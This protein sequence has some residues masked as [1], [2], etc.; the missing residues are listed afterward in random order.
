MQLCGQHALN[1][2]LQG[3]YFSAVDLSDIGRG[4]DDREKE[5]MLAAGADTEDAIRFAAEDSGCVCRVYMGVGVGVG[6]WACRSCV[7]WG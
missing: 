6:M 2:L 5:L 7:R 4:L 1:A 3:P